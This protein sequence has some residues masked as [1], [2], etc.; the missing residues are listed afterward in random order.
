MSKPT[1]IVLN[2]AEWDTSN[3]R[4]MQPK[5][6]ERGG[7]SI[8]IISTQTNR[9]L[10][11]STPL[12]MTW[13]IADFVDEKGESDGK[14]SMSLNFPNEDYKTD[15]TDAFLSKLKDFENQILDDAVKYSDA[16]FGEDLSREVVKHNFFPFLKYSKD[17]LT[18]KVDPSKPPSIRARVPCYNGKWN[19][20]IYDTQQ[21]RIFPSDNE[22]LT[23]MDFVPKLSNVA[24]VLQCGGLWFGG[25]GW[26]LTWRVNQVVVKPREV[27]SVFGK[28]HINLSTEELETLEKSS[29]Q[30]DDD[31]YMEPATKKETTTVEVVDSDDEE[32][33]EEV[34]EEPAPTPKKKVVKKAAAPPA[35]EEGEEPAPAPKKKVAKKKVVA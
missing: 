16:W 23:P 9:G 24:C 35:T 8:S 34:K 1:S 29:V 14:F 2:S 19:L 10:S 27:V 11:V 13:G 5:V 15:G 22:N 12:M 26:G 18:K 3:I 31:N 21:N 32:A 28:C 6:N 17:K 20:E 25:K 30:D 33:V 7:K 4:Y